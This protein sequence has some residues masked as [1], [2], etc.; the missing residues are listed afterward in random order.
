[1]ALLFGVPDADADVP[2]TDAVVIALKTRTVPADEAVAESLA[3]LR[4]A[5]GR[6]TS[7]SVYFKYCSTFDSTD[8]GN[9]GPVADALLDALGETVTLIC[10]ASPEHGRTDVPRPPLRRRRAAL[11]VARCGTTR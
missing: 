6:A 5:A 11:R 2:D 7:S 4:V 9:I 1:M 3:A 10:P 8:D